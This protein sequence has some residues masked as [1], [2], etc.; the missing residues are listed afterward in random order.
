MGRRCTV[1]V[2]MGGWVAGWNTWLNPGTHLQPKLVEHLSGFV[3]EIHRHRLHPGVVCIPRIVHVSSVH[4][5]HN[6]GRERYVARKNNFLNNGKIASKTTNWRLVFVM[7]DSVAERSGR[8]PQWTTA[9]RRPQPQVLERFF[10]R[11]GTF[12]GFPLPIVS[13]SYGQPTKSA[14]RAVNAN[15]FFL[16]FHFFSSL[17]FFRL[18]F[19][20][21]SALHTF[22]PLYSFVLFYVL[23]L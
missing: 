9:N 16:F 18:S 19:V 6:N 7:L 17:P 11:G 15:F 13:T 5:D 3:V 1:R 23:L 10:T 21:F 12:N 22:T 14:T 20:L 4:L 2:D 8:N